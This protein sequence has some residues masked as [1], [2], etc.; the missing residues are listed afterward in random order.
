MRNGVTL[1]SDPRISTR[2][3]RL[4]AATGAAAAAVVLLAPSAPART[5]SVVWTVPTQADGTRFTVTAGSTLALKLTASTSLPKAAI[6]IEAVDGIPIGA[7]LESSRGSVARAVFHWTPTAIGEYVIRF[8]ASAGSSAAAPTLTYTVEVRTKPAARYPRSYVLSDDRVAHS[9]VVLEL[10]A[11]HVRPRESARVVT[12]LETATSDGTPNLVLVLEGL[13]LNP[14]TTWYRVRLPILPNN[15]TG[16]V[17][18]R[19]LDELRTVHTHLYVD[20][21]T[22][23][24]TLTRDGVP[25]FRTIVGVGRDSWPTPSG[26]YYIL[27][28]LTDFANPVYGPVAFGTSAR[29]PTLTD[30]AGGGFVAVHGTNQPQL[31]PG[32]VSHGCIR[33]PNRSI[34]RLARLVDVG[35]PLTIR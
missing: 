17:N 19:S 11:V 21:A 3:S 28:R 10:A 18:A 32:R 2:C 33:M 34:L 29:S 1:V 6:A 25:V 22:L 13:D 35:S 23:T 27:D 9:A 8:G 31:L 7:T 12:R 26:E 16:W 30:W 24:A 4:A 15:S 5:G 14:S 20:R